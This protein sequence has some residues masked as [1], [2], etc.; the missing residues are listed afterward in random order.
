M[1]LAVRRRLDV[2]VHDWNSDDPDPRLGIRCRRCHT[3]LI[4]ALDTIK[5]GQRVPGGW[6][7]GS[8]SPSAFAPY[9]VMAVRVIGSDP[10]RRV[11]GW[12]RAGQGFD[13]LE[14]CAEQAR[15]FDRRE[16]ARA[17]GWPAFDGDSGSAEYAQ[18]V[19]AC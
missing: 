4:V 15:S 17:S 6:Y 19:T 2:C 16:A 3:L 18:E 5:I 1:A 10:R 12:G 13:A 14:A 11:S 8:P 9:D 7:V